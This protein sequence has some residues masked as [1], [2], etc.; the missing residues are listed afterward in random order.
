MSFRFKSGPL[1][2]SILT[3][4]LDAI[5]IMRKEYRSDFIN[6]VQCTKSIE[7]YGYLNHAFNMCSSCVNDQIL[8]VGK[9]SLASESAG[10]TR[11]FAI[12]NF[13][14]QSALKPLH[15]QLML[16]LRLFKSDGTFDQIEQFNRLRINSKGSWVSCFDLTKATDRFPIQLQQVLLGVIVGQKFAKC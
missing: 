7:L 11:L 15:N 1:G 14:V 9:I 6:Y 4:H 2:P 16:V 13:W 8:K 3:S 10:K 12:C 5:A